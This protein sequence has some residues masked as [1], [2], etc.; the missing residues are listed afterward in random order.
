MC[1]HNIS[2]CTQ[3]L[4]LATEAKQCQ[5]VCPRKVGRAKRWWA[6]RC[7][8]AGT[9]CDASRN[10]V[11]SEVESHFPLGPVRI[12][13]FPR[14]VEDHFP[15]PPGRFSTWKIH[16]SG[17]GDGAQGRRGEPAEGGGVMV[18]N[19]R[20]CPYSRSESRVHDHCL[21]QTRNNDN[22]YGMIVAGEYYHVLA[23][24]EEKIFGKN[25]PQSRK[26]MI[27]LSSQK[28]SALAAQSPDSKHSVGAPQQP[29]RACRDAKMF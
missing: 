15:K 12:A 9:T 17:N 28:K 16:A 1:E 11:E 2:N 3:W 25:A 29:R 24:G 18:C 21:L 19:P 5:L 26:G 13:N 14:N 20:H 22:K 23:G 8:R 6:A 7:R 10:E 4:N 27:V